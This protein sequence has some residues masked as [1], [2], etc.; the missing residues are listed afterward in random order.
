MQ[1]GLVQSSVASGMITTLALFQDTVSNL[2]RICNTLLPF[3][4]Q[5]HLR[6]SLWFV[7]ITRFSPT[8]CIDWRC[9]I[10]SHF[11]TSK[12][13]LP[14][15][16]S[17]RL[18]RCTS[19]KSM[20]LTGSSQFP[21]Q[22]LLRFCSSVSWKSV[23]RCE[24]ILSFYGFYGILNLCLSENPFDYDYNDLGESFLTS[25]HHFRSIMPQDLDYFCLSIQRDLHQITAV[26]S[27][28]KLSAS[29]PYYGLLQYTNPNPRDIVFTKMYDRSWYH[30]FVYCNSFTLQESTSSSIG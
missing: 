20:L 9:R 24:P 30:D 17:S 7:S 22:L 12:P 21:R 27:S 13:N 29:Q 15:C 3:A 2:E 26:R 1:N 16:W 10:Y 6:L 18:T 14:A 19:S 8:F 28:P 5:A 23:R 25:L 11:I 4:Y